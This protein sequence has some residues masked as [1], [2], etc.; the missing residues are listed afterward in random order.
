MKTTLNLPD[1]LMRAVKMRAVQHNKTLQD[2]IAELLR[3]GLAHEPENDSE[4]RHRVHLPLIHCA[5]AATPEEEMTPERVADVLI[6]AEAA[7]YSEPLR[8]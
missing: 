3:H 2:T 7:D 4:V 8:H 1:E 5:H 6:Q